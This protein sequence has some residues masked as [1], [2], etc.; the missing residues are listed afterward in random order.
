[1]NFQRNTNKQ[2]KFSLKNFYIVSKG[3][4]FES[5]RS[6]EEILRSRGAFQ[7]AL[8]L[9]QVLEADCEDRLAVLPFYTGSAGS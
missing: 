3:L 9:V 7:E 5:R 6:K 4:R 1:V 2:F 8:L